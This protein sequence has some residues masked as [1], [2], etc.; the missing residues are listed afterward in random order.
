MATTLKILSQR[1]IKLVYFF[2][3][4][5]TGPSV[6][7]LP[8]RSCGIP[9]P[10]DLTKGCNV[11]VGNPRFT[12]LSVI[13]TRTFAYSHTMSV[14]NPSCDTNKWLIVDFVSPKA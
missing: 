12:N 5:T 13:H 3:Y 8:W 11:T 10:K 1:I 9:T 2:F 4:V 7:R 14:K 6:C